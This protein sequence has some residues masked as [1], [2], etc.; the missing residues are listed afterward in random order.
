MVAP[1]S[2]DP[3]EPVLNPGLAAG[4]LVLIVRRARP[5]IAF[6]WL[7]EMDGRVGDVARVTSVA[8]DKLSAKLDDGRSFGFASLRPLS[9]AS[10]GSR[11]P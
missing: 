4:D 2:L 7:E 6:R 3:V 8:R 9:A 1:G 11:S 10:R 5:R